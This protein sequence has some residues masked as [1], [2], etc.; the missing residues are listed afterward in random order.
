MQTLFQIWMKPLP[1]GAL[2][3]KDFRSANTKVSAAMEASVNCEDEF[4]EGKEKSP[5]T[6]NKVYFELNAISL[7]FIY[8]RK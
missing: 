4:K 5:L 3:P 6:D 8:Q 2:K 1:I 7:A